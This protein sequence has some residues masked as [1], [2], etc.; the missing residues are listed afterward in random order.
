MLPET[1]LSKRIL[2]LEERSVLT[3]IIRS[4]LR[5]QGFKNLHAFSN[6]NDAS[7]FLQNHTVDLV[8]ADLDNRDGSCFSWL[9]KE[10]DTLSKSDTQVLLAAGAVNQNMVMRA[11]KMGIREFIVKPFSEKLLLEKVLHAIQVPPLAAT[12]AKKDKGNQVF[13]SK[14]LLCLDDKKRFLGQLGQP[15]FNPIQANLPDALKLLQQDKQIDV[16]L[17]DETVAKNNVGLI[18]QLLK[19]QAMGQI[20]LVLLLDN[21]DAKHW[22]HLHEA[23]LQYV[24]PNSL[25]DDAVLNWVH[26]LQEKKAA[27]L[28]TN[29]MVQNLKQEALNNRSLS[30]VIFDR[31]QATCDE[32]EHTRKDISQHR[33]ASNLINQLSEQLAGQSIALHYLTQTILL[34]DDEASQK[35]QT[36]TLEE[37]SLKDL[38]EVANRVFAQNL[39]S[40]SAELK[41]LPS[42]TKA[43]KKNKVLLNSVIMLILKAYLDEVDYRSS[44]VFEFG[45][46]AGVPNL[47]ISSSFKDMP[48]LAS[49]T[50]PQKG[51]EPIEY[52]PIWTGEF[53]KLLQK[54]QLEIKAHYSTAK[55]KLTLE[56][57]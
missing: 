50:D 8:L 10:R 6:Q 9:E 23:G 24:L 53:L 2:L 47:S 11:Y 33:S 27:C 51:H 5:D 55:A 56:L 16:L 19:M 34:L 12:I 20:D 43:F 17:I 30:K 4:I 42:D 1:L 52:I 49:L 22:H 21:T 37:Y 36:E 15:P 14:T 40:R 46:E 25:P 29:S 32:I 3:N 13:D 38:F 28:N 18:P 57:Y 54:S 7:Q 31:L 41:L 45:S 35:L 39:K 44:I 26:I 48:K